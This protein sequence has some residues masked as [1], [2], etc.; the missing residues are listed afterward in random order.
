MSHTTYIVFVNAAPRAG[1]RG[2]ATSGNSSGLADIWDTDAA[3][4]TC[5]PNMTVTINKTGVDTIGSTLIFIDVSSCGPQPCFDSGPGYA[6]ATGAQ[7]QNPGNVTGVSITPT[8]SAGACFASM[9]VDAHTIT[10][11][12]TPALF[13]SSVATRTG[14]VEDA[15]FPDDE[16][17]GYAV[18]YYSTAGKITL[19]WQESDILNNWA[20]GITCYKGQ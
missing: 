15:D 1:K 7:T 14:N 8:T 6:G 20:N 12:L 5:S 9:A 13:L 3:Q 2:S 11:I 18:V 10:G 16:N 19:V 4:T 17:N